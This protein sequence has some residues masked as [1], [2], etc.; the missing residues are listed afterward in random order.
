MNIQYMYHDGRHS[1]KIYRYVTLPTQHSYLKISGAKKNLNILSKDLR[2]NWL[3]IHKQYRNFVLKFSHTF[4]I[5]VM[6]IQTLLFEINLRHKNLL[7]YLFKSYTLNKYKT[8]H[9]ASSLISFYIQLTYFFNNFGWND[10]AE[11]DVLQA[12]GVE[13]SWDTGGRR[14]CVKL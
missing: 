8:K 10:K 9:L 11:Y 14:G 3:K 12:A 4:Y 13:E 6:V 1:H 7:V 5:T 2:Y